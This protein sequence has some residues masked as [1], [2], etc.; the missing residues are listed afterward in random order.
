M[1]L[2]VLFSVDLFLL[3]PFRPPKMAKPPDEIEHFDKAELLFTPKNYLATVHPALFGFEGW[4]FGFD[5]S[6]QL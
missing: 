5:V 1:I 3:V 6:L 2:C 4:S